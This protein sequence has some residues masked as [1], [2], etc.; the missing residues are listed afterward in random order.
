MKT[1]SAGMLV[2]SAT[3]LPLTIV[4]PA[5]AQQRGNVGQ[6]VERQFMNSLGNTITGQPNYSYQN[7]P[8]NPYQGQRGM[9]GQ[10]NYQPQWGS[11]YYQR[12]Y[13][14]PVQGY[15][16]QQRQAYYPQQQPQQGYYSRQQPAAAQRYLLPAQYAGTT[17]GS[18]INY[19]GASYVVNPDGTMRPA[20]ASM[21]QPAA[22]TLRYQIP[23]QFAGTTP[24]ST[25]TYGGANYII[26]NDSTMSPFAGAVAR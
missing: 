20:T 4:G 14:Q 2:L 8:Y 17:P 1:R 3:L 15:Y 25:I 21:A 5:H 13:Q 16:P 10:P 12:G 9:Y 26:N 22:N 11:S 18:T 6:Q 7:Q 24:G 23:G 19:G